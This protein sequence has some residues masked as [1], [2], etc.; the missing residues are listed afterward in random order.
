MDRIENSEQQNTKHSG[1]VVP[2]QLL[3]VTVEDNSNL[4]CIHATPLQ[5]H[6]L[7]PSVLTQH[8]VAIGFANNQIKLQQVSSKTVL[9]QKKHSA[10]VEI[11]ILV[12]IITSMA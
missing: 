7:W 1:E 8:S 2:P 11:H 5:Q 12:K 4:V 10:S 3:Y 6:E 9:L